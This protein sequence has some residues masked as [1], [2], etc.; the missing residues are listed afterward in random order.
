[1]TTATTKY[2][3]ALRRL[4]WL[5][6]LLILV[7]YLAIEQRGLFGRGSPGRFVMMQSHFWL[8]LTVF[9]LA[10]WRISHRWRSPMPPI[11]PP[12]PRWQ[13]GI[14]VTMHVLLYAFFFVMPV[15]G[16]ATAWTDEK[17][18]YLPFTDIA[19]P[20]LLAPNEVLAHSLE[21]LHKAIGKAFYYVI[22]FHVLAAIYHHFVRRDD[23]LRRMA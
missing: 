11:T 5:M 6:A 17:I 8:G 22:G 4:H 23:T 15:L 2:S 16:I 19:L 3:P 13:H 1:M 7:V 10:L 20:A 9:A 18:L 14:G 21:D 12:L